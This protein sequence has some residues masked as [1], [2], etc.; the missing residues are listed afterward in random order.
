MAR[1]T[2]KYL[3]P[4]EPLPLYRTKMMN[5]V[6]YFNSPRCRPASA[7]SCFVISLV[8]RLSVLRRKAFH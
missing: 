3:E 7:R 1:E 8:V 2:S 4:G 5:D 6:M